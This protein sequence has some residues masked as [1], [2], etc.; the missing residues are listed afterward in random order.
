MKGLNKV[1]VFQFILGVIV[2]AVIFGGT[3]ALAAGII[4]QPKTATVKINGQVVDLQGYLIND[5]H[6][7][8]LRDLDAALQAYNK[9]FS[10]VWDGPNNTILIDTSR[11]YDPNEQLPQAAQPTPSATVTADGSGGVSAM[12]LADKTID[13][14]ELSREDFSQQANPA[15]F[16]DV[17]T[18]GAYNALRQTIVD[19][20]TILP[21]DNTDSFNPYYAYANFVD[22]SFIPGENENGTTLQ[23]I[24]Y[25]L[26]GR[27]G[28]Y[29]QYTAG[30]EPY[31]KGYYNYP[32]YGIVKVY[33]N[34]YLSAANGATDSLIQEIS[35]LTDRE[36]VVR[37]ADALCDK[38][39]YGSG[40]GGSGPNEVF[41]SASPV[42]GLCGAYASNFLY[43]C[44]R[45]GIPCLICS[46]SD[47]AWNMVYVEG[48]WQIVDVTNYGTARD[49]RWLF[50]EN[51]PKQDDNPSGLRFLQEALIP[52][53]TK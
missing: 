35:S 34:D 27:M 17:Y 22:K 42:K 33:K 5:S 16:D 36:K 7:F 26:P 43:L 25:S 37:L 28:G 46:D 53:S 19:R 13:G 39:T 4:A 29:Y 51:Y 23:F 11:G 30:V 14:R 12:P 32:G 52:G 47:H 44:Q 10:V 18:R 9:G 50:A 2:G 3:A 40:T 21:G 1:G 8:Q 38:M 24:R 20:D 41:T 48:K 45:A 15:I 31:V 6:Y 49:M